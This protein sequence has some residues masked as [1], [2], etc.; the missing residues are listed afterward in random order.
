MTISSYHHKRSDSVPVPLTGK[1][2][3]RWVH[4]GTYLL[5]IFLHYNW[6]RCIIYLTTRCIHLNLIY[7]STWGQGEEDSM[8]KKLVGNW[9]VNPSKRPIWAWLRV[10]F[11]PKGDYASTQF[12]C[13]WRH[14]S[15]FLSILIFLYAQTQATPLWVKISAFHPIL[16]TKSEIKVWQD[17]EHPYQ[18]QEYKVVKKNSAELCFMSQKCYLIVQCESC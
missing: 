1:K 2:L 3:K 12:V 4:F 6:T 14:T 17:G 13:F 8:T 15:M 18:S 16:N 10:R 7:G 11:T 5:N 9:K